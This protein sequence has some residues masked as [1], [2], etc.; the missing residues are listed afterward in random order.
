MNL[1]ELLVLQNGYSA[2]RDGHIYSK[3]SKKFLKET[4]GADGYA[5]IT[6]SIKGHVSTHLVHRLVAT[7]F[8]KNPCNY[9]EVN[10]RDEDKLNN[11]VENLEWCT[12]KY[13]SN[14]GN[15]KYNLSKTRCDKSILGQCGVGF[16][17]RDKVW[18]A[19]IRVNGRLIHL[20]NF[21]NFQ[22]A[23]IARENGEKKYYGK[24]CK[25]I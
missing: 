8:I 25:N 19:N 18:F 10:H 6:V 13:N 12:S 11:T 9:S 1:N 23:V 21:N 17:K 24:H 15:R 16:H 4:V 2:T 7:A 20:G 3:K 5:R 22:E 14:Y